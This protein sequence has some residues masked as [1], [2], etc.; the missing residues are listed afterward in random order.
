MEDHLVDQ[1]VILVADLVSLAVAD[2]AVEEMMI[3][4]CLRPFVVI[5]EMNVKFH[6]DQQVES[7]FIVVTVLK[8]WAG[9]DRTHQDQ[10]D[11]ISEHKAQA[12]TKTEINLHH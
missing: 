5:V 1:D 6:L 12:L 7:Q 3:V 4:K 10:K 2:L 8:K 9:E 11:L